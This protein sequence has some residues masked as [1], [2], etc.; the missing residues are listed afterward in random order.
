L[1]DGQRQET[2]ELRL[3]GDGDVDCIQIRISA[4]TV[5]VI[6]VAGRV[7]SR[8]TER[9]D[10]ELWRDTRSGSGYLVV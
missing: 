10:W 6:K 2:T 7:E 9:Q 1:G 4:S 5:K 8:E 3:D